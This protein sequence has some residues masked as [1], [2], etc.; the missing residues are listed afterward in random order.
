ME[1]VEETAMLLTFEDLEDELKVL[2]IA[3]FL[4]YDIAE[5]HNDFHEVLRV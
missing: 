3:Q 2:F 1:L 5:Y 4:F